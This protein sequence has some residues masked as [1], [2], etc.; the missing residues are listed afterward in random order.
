MS[1]WTPRLLSLPSQ[2]QSPDLQSTAWS[3]TNCHQQLHLHLSHRAEH[4]A[5]LKAQAGLNPGGGGG[6][7]V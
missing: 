3:R 5:P 4:W 6:I 1:W 7:G 2:T